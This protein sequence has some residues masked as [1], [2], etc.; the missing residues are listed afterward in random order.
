MNPKKKTIGTRLRTRAC[1]HHTMYA[2]I[3]PAIAPDAPI[4]GTVEPALNTDVRQ[5]SR[6]RPASK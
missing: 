4:V 5:R 6:R 3:T 1:G 2:P